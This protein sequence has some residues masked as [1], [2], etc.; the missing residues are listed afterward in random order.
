MDT[1]LRRYLG[2]GL[3]E[4]RRVGL[5]WPYFPETDCY[6]HAHG[7]TNYGVN[8]LLC[9][10]VQGEEISLFYEGSAPYYG[11][12]YPLG[13]TYKGNIY[14][15]RLRTEGE[16]VR[17]L[18][19]LRVLTDG[20]LLSFDPPQPAPAVP[21]NETGDY[22]RDV[23]VVP[24]RVW[25]DFESYEAARDSLD[26]ISHTFG[27]DVYPFER[28]LEQ[29]YPGYG[30]L[31]Y[32]EVGTGTVHGPDDRLFFITEA[33]RRYW[34]DVPSYMMGDYGL[35]DW[36]GAN[37]G[38]GFYLLGDA[39]RSPFLVTWWMNCAYKTYIGS[40]ESRQGGSCCWTLYLPAMEVFAW[41]R[42]EE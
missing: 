4:T 1:V 12:E 14:R 25:E 34:L 26:E 16:D 20:A 40:G 17:F 41:F 33:G 7:D 37:E 38:R 39:S 13:Y 35:T 36:E 5:S 19:N 21:Q 23:T 11:S 28:K 8:R 6:Y 15:V 18:S 29:E 22:G 3:E 31:V 9:G 10:Y 24:P 42:P 30:T 32:G 2:L 27:E